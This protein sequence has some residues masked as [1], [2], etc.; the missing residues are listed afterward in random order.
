[1]EF[2]VTIMNYCSSHRVLCGKVSGF[3]EKERV[4]KAQALGAGA[5]AKK[6]YVSEKL[7]LAVKKELDRST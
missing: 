6:P 2:F 7:G 1:M 5:Y 4:T 3:S